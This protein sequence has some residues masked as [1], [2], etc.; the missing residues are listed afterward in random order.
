MPALPNS[1]MDVLAWW[2]VREPVLPLLAEIARKYLCIPASSAPSDRLSSASGNVCTKLR[3]S[4]DPTNLEM[5]VYL[6]EN[7]D[8]DKMTYDSNITPAPA[9]GV[10]PAQ[11]KQVNLD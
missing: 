4:L 8:K 10:Q 11:P 2:K 5:I 1:K 3:S 7:G 9:P 6:H